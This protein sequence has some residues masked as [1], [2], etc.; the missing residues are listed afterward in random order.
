MT[1]QELD[2]LFNEEMKIVKKMRRVSEER[3]EALREL[4]KLYENKILNNEKIE[5]AKSKYEELKEKYNRLEKERVKARG[6]W[7]YL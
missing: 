1:I 4:D 3:K 5:E 6:K 2:I 7:L